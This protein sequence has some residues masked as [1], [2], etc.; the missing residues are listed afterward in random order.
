MARRASR[1]ADA[2]REAMTLS[3]GETHVFVHC[4]FIILIK[5]PNVEALIFWYQHQ[6]ISCFDVV[7][8]M[9]DV[10]KDG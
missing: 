6:T 5:V 10:F 4:T 2:A 3:R 7:L 8:L 1:P 9:K